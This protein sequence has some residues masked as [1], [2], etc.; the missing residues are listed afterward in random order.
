MNTQTLKVGDLIYA[1]S[2]VQLLQFD[3][4]IIKFDPSQTYIGPSPIKVFQLKRP[5]NLLLTETSMLDKKY[6]KVLYNGDEWYVNEKDVSEI[7]PK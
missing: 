4:I 1:P 3:D 2:E 7:A 6:L 5:T